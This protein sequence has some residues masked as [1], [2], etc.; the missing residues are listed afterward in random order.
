M[1]VDESLPSLFAMLSKSVMSKL[2]GFFDHGISFSFSSK[3]LSALIASTYLKNFDK[4]GV[5][6]FPFT[7]FC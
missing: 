3:R 2:S 7:P 5:L 1:I 4:F 6:V